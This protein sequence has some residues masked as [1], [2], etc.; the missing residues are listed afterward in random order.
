VGAYGAY[1]AG[2]VEPAAA[3]A[4]GGGGRRWGLGIAG[5]GAA[6]GQPSG[7]RLKLVRSLQLFHPDGKPGGLNGSRPLL[8]LGL[9]I[10]LDLDHNVCGSLG[11]WWCQPALRQ[12]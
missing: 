2:Y 4:Q 8:D 6:D 10:N 12:L 1:G 5:F 3:D 7:A 11:A 9:G